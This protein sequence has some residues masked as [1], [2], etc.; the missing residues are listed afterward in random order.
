M[1]PE[2]AYSVLGLSPGGADPSDIQKAYRKKALECHPDRVHGE[3]EKDAYARKFLEVRDAYEALKKAGFP[4]P[5]P[6]EVVADPV[7]IL[8]YEARFKKRKGEPEFEVPL[9]E[10]LGF[11]SGPTVDQVFF[12]GL[13]LPALGVGMFLSLRWLVGVVRGDGAP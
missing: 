3:A 11:G 7:D 13:L 2:A 1:T 5:K 10:K 8:R 4:V 6:Q 12:W 9:R